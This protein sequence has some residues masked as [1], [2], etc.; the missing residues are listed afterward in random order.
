MNKFRYPE[1]LIL[2]R[3]NHPKK[4]YD[5]S[6]SFLKNTH[7]GQLK[8]FSNELEFLLSFCCDENIIKHRKIII[9]I[10]AG[11]GNHLVYLVKMFPTIEWHL[12]DV[13]FDDRLRSIKNV[14][15]EE[16]YFKDSDL[17]GYINMKEENQDLDLYLISD[18]RNLSYNSSD[19]N[20]E[21]ELK[22][23][24]DMELQ[25]EWIMKLKPKYSMVKFRPPFPEKEVF[26]K[27]GTDYIEYLDGKIYKQPWARGK[28]IETRLII[29]GNKIKLVKYNLL[30]YEQQ[31]FYHN[32][33][34]RQIEYSFNFS[35]KIDGLKVN[36]HLTL[37]KRYD[38][39]YIITL[40]YQYFIRTSKDLPEDKIFKK[41][42]IALDLVSKD[43]NF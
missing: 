28:S 29:P 8:L 21:E 12:Y 22:V 37:N 41:I 7:L 30:D 24:E 17:N 23:L 10:G 13:R 36:S 32:S 5:K 20:I 18:I 19:W 27:L 31:M 6:I 25:K 2:D 16:R 1:D 34:L 9:Y 14:F 42:I 11:P 3:K 4:H 33:V 40:M 43:H 39:A 15:I 38:C 26:D 35:D